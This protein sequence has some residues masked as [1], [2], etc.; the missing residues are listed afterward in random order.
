MQRPPD[1]AMRPAPK[2][3][4]LWPE[5]QRTLELWLLCGTQWRVGGQVATGL[6]YA[7]VEALMRMRRMGQGRRAARLMDELQIMERATLAEW[8]RMRETQQ[9]RAAAR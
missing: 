9:H 6:D 4:Y 2:V 7:G 5:H 3:F 1:G 8:A